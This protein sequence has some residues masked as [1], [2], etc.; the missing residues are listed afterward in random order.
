VLAVVAGLVW[1]CLG[2]PVLFV[3][4]RVG[5]NGRL[6]RLY[7]FRSMVADAEELLRASPA[8]YERYAA[9]DFKLPE[10]EDPRVT[11]LGAMLRRTSLDELPQLWNV[12]RGDMSLVG[13]RPVVPAELTEYGDYERLLQRAKP[14]ITGVWQVSGRSSVHYPERARMDLRY[15]GQR[16]LAVDLRLLLRT[17]PAVISRRGAL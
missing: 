11:R 10:G 8:L 6:F 1:A 2:R 9:G 12:L 16:S 15:I 7:K 3:Q 17:L 14:G 13:P 4:E 5:R